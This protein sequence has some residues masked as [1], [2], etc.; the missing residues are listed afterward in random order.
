MRRMIGAWIAIVAL[1]GMAG[2]A[3]AGDWTGSIQ[4]GGSLPSGDYAGVDKG[5]AGSGWALGG[6]LDY[7]LNRSWAIGFDGSLGQNTRGASGEVTSLGS[8][9]TLTVDD[10]KFKTWQAGTHA[11]YFFPVPDRMPVKWYGLVGAGFYGFTEDRTETV[12]SGATSTTTSFK[13]TDKR[14]GVRLGLGGLWW[15]SPKVGIHAGVDYNVAFL[16]KDQSPYSSLQY[17]GVHVGLT[18]TIPSNASQ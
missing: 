5:D 9:V 10:D 15:A 16:D 11:K 13:G 2:T 7:G 12:A 18:F 8:G 4:G 1:W 14:A 3:T 6:S 17:M